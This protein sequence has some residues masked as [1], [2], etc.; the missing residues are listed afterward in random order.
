MRNFCF[1][2]TVFVA[3]CFAFAADL[4]AIDPGEC[5]YIDD[6]DPQVNAQ[7]YIMS[8]LILDPYIN[9]AVGSTVAVA[10]DYFEDQGGE[11]S[12]M[13]K[14]G[15]EVTI[16]ETGSKHVWARLNFAD[17]KDMAQIP[18]PVGGNELDIICWGGQG[19]NNTQEY[20]VTYLKWDNATSATFTFGSDDSSE[21][22]FN[23]EVLHSYPADVDWAA[24]NGGIHEATV[25]KGKWNILVVGAY[26]TGGEWGISVQVDPVPDEV[27]NI[28]PAELFAVEPVAKL[29]TT[30]GKI[31]E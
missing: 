26:E 10:A 14:E 11:A 2:F 8:W 12:L 4:Y 3:L 21:S 17:L 30:W 15:D 20:L 25:V 24:G 27:N 5:E 6:N 13:P 22:Y 16:K 1:S 28:G 29:A 23:G 9:A 7:G 19:P 18:A 31:K